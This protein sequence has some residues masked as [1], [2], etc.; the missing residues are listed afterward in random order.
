[1]FVLVVVVAWNATVSAQQG[2]APDATPQVVTAA[3]TGAVTDKAGA[4]IG[5]AKVT[6]SNAAGF[7]QE[8]TTDDQGLYAVMDIAAGEY[9]LVVVS[10]KG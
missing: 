5:G 9:K 4:P 6:V 3:I 1:L 2:G 8:T 10:S 7:T